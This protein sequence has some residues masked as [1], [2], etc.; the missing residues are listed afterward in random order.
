[1]PQVVALGDINLDVIV[2]VAE[3]PRPGGEAVTQQGAVLPGGSA[4]N[5]ARALAALGVDVGL[6]ACAGRDPLGEMVLERLRAAGVDTSQVQRTADAPTGLMFIPVTPDGERTMFGFRGANIC[7]CAEEMDLDYIREA[8]LLHLSG[9]AL[10]TPPQR[11]AALAAAHAAHEAGIP[12][13]LDPGICAAAQQREALLRLLPEVTLLLPDSLEAELLTG[14]VD[15]PD[16]L[17]EL[18]GRGAQFVALKLGERGAL[19]GTRGQLLHLPPFRVAPVDA[20]GA[21]D[22]FNA[23]IIFGR[24]RGLSVPASGVLAVALGALTVAREGAATPPTLGEVYQLLQ[25]AL[26]ELAWQ[27]WWPAIQ[28]VLGIRYL[29]THTQYPISN[30]QYPA[31]DHLGGER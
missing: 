18:L 4:A 20:T 29:P 10:M 1:M 21:G 12:L 7:L 22:A 2:R 28:E 8:W 16:A 17:D 15:P 6:I 26:D 13:S 14:L 24:L 9:Y 25:R 31:P 5:T 19:L 11:D 27:E 23:G 30:T 3:F